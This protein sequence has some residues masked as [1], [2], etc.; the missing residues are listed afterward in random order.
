MAHLT[1][2]A[3]Y[4][5]LVDR[6]NRFPQGAPPRKSCS[7]SSNCSSPSARPG[8]SRGCPS[9][10]SRVD[11]ASQAWRVPPA[12]AQR[13]LETLAGRALLLDMDDHG[14]QRYV[15][16]PP[17]AGFFEFSM[18]RVRGD[19]DQRMLSELFYQ[20][21][22][23]E[24]EFIKAL[25]RAARRSSGGSS[26]TSR[27]CPPGPRC[28]CS[29]TSAPA[30]SSGRRRPS[31]SAMCYCRHKMSHLGRA[32]DAPMDICMTFSDGGRVARQARVRAAGRRRRVPRPAAGGARAGTSCSSAR[33]CA[34]ASTSS[35]TAAAAAARR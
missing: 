5:A 2:R 9:S 27:R 3:G 8:S 6:L 31:G 14:V 17:M 19:I 23:V 11:E 12:E 7:R 22:N 4:R 20:Y 25:F 24:E 28:T 16:P 26:C 1:A 32:C 33:T 34:R 35:A 10:R 18:M 15:L 13:T 21:L 30:T 29:T